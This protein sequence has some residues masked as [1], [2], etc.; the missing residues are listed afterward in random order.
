VHTLRSLADSRAIIAR[1]RTRKRAVVIGAS[2]IGLEVAA[3]LRAREHRGPCRGAREAADGA[4]PRARMGDFVRALHEEHGVSS[5]SRNA[6]GDRAAAGQLKSGGRS[7]PT[8][9]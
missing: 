2:F 9:W 7:T 4:H 3:S 1:P 5:I 6:V 8:S